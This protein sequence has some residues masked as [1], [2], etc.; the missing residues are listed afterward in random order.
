MVKKIIIG[1]FIISLLIF[2]GCANNELDIFNE[3]KEQLTNEILELKKL[4]SKK[5]DEINYLQ[6]LNTNKTAELKE[7]RDSIDM[8]RFSSYARLDDYNDTFFNL[9]ENY[10]IISPYVIKDDWYMISDDYFQI[11][12]LE[13]ENAVKVEFYTLRMESGEGP[14]L[15]FTDTD[16]TDGWTYTSDNISEIIDKHKE[17]LSGDFSYVPYFLIYTEVTLGD[18]KVIK[19]PKLPIYNK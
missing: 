7:L 15:A 6:R 19:T 3:E 1:M 10:K 8:V 17:K 12:L 13:Y 14:M 18:G 9:K 11:A 4:V 5:D 16:P 2:S